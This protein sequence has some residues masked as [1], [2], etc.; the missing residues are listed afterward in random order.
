MQ[1]RLP[2][3]SVLDRTARAADKTRQNRTAQIGTLALL[4]GDAYVHQTEPDGA[5][6][7]MPIRWLVAGQTGQVASAHGRMHL[8]NLHR[9]PALV[10]SLL[11]LAGM[12]LWA[13]EVEQ[14][15]LIPFPK[16][17]Q[18]QAGAFSLK[19]SLVLEVPSE[20][21]EPLGALLNQELALAG[22]DRV[23]VR[24]LK[25][26]GLAFRLASPQAQAPLPALPDVNVPE[27]YALDVRPG[28]VICT[29]RESAGLFYGLQ[30]LCQLIRANRQGD[31]LPCLT[32]RD[33]PSLRWRC[34]QD[35]LTRGPS[36][37][38][39]TLKFEASLGAYLKLNLMTWYMEYQ[40][41]FKKHPAIGP[42]NGSLTPEELSS[43]VA[44]AKP[45]HMDILGNQQSFGHFG[46]ILSHPQYAALRETGDVL[47]PVREE[48]YQLLDDL[49]S[50]VCPLLPFP[51]FNVCCDETDGLGTGP[52]RDLAAK[53]GLGGVY[54]S[55]IRRV[56]DLLRD[57]YRKRM[58]M[59]G[60][61]IL[62]H[63]AN[64]QDVPK[65][66]IM[67]TWGYDAR[68]SFDDQITPFAKSGYEFFVC[69]G[70]N[71][72]SRIL[73]DFGVAATN[74]QNFVRDGIRQG[75]LGM[76]NTDW[77]DDGEAINAV[78]WHADAWAA[79]CAWNASRTPLAVFNGRVGAVL[80][81]ETNDH[82]GRAVEL[83]SRTHR[84][85]GMNGMFNAR[86][87]E[88]DFA[89]K[90]NPAATLSAASNLLAVVRPAIDHLEV[91]RREARFNDQVLEAFL[92][93]ARRM[94]F[95]GQR[96]LDGLQAAQ[97]YERAGAV[98]S[99]ED[100]LAQ[101][102]GLVRQN[103]TR[104]ERLRGQFASLWLAESKP[105]ALDWTLARYTNALG[106]YDDILRKLAA[107]RAQA[108]AG[109]PLPTPEELGLAIPR[110][111]SRRVRPFEKLSTPLAPQAPWAV[112]SATMRLGLVVRTGD[113]DRYDCPVAVEMDL[114]D[115]LIGK[116]AR[117]FVLGGDGAAQEVLAQIDATGRPG[118]AGLVLVLPGKRPKQTKVAVHVYLGASEV[119]SLLPG[120]VSTRAGDH[121]MQ[122]MENDRVRLLLGPAGAHVYRW[123]LKSAEQRDLTMPGETD[124]AGFSDMASQR[125]TPYRL[126]C[127][128]RGPAMVEYQCVTDDGHTKTITLYGGS[129]WM[130]VLL[131]EPTTVYWDFDTPKSFAADGPTPGQWLFSNGQTGAVGREADGVPAQVKAPNTYWGMKSNVD[132]LALG[133]ITPEVAAFH[134]IAP[135]AG[136]GGAGIEGSPPA[137]HFVTFAGPLPGSP[138]ET[139]ERLRETLD[140]RRLPQVQCHA[141]Q[142][143]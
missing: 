24:G 113:V 74:I 88:N 77:E 42:T 98:S 109:Q 97:L 54:V 32:I 56:H 75:A 2:A 8:M 121:D 11:A 114:S 84:L 53:I 7:R 76:I 122:W 19:Q 66:T 44:H 28:A 135:G 142:V 13:V 62:Q 22:F 58:M 49:Y 79:E 35:D 95:I 91:C 131:G 73:P 31:A 55:H 105:Y 106:G 45:L 57:K 63:P 129:S 27:A 141:L 78:K 138:G 86:F 26:E 120:A 110:P 139:M 89:P 61:I 59:W 67:L 68:P 39:D 33:W 6:W 116:P 81:G 132:G 46:R 60:D 37:R 112:P 10:V 124:W 94:E 102:E 17:A 25:Q 136:A 20:Q 29:A 71:N 48:T 125:Q 23:P 130:E 70:V 72:W 134:V 99:P 41:A 52:S 123:E 115:A 12:S 101:V 82:F 117:A 85:P 87:W 34:F 118:K 143:R 14:L 9:L 128:A 107:A 96:M 4:S 103:R 15:R 104:L 137:R 5:W 65:D 50:E 40:Y 21:T 30:T 108:T 119:S 127:M 43:L 38:L 133:L 100:A 36:S 51:W 69:P 126:E 93:G 140:L 1:R 90:A 3:E 83:L 92:F 111:L 47:T 16:E 64:L 80:F 18:L